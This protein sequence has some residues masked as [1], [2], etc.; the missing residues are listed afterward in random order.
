M[1]D[2]PDESKDSLSTASFFRRIDYG[3]LKWNKMYVD[4]KHKLI[5]I[6]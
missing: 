3:M 1:G 5:T 6:Q 2:P 4:Y